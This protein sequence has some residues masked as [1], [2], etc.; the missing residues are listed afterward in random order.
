MCP[1]CFESTAFVNSLSD[2]GH[3]DPDHVFDG[4]ESVAEVHRRYAK[5]IEAHGLA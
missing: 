2:A 4:C 1:V 5:E 3:P